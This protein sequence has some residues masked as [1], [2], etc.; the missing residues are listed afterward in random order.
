MRVRDQYGAVHDI[1]ESQLA[2]EPWRSCEVVAEVDQPEPVDA[3]KPQQAPSQPDIKPIK[4]AAPRPA[5]ED[6]E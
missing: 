4:K 5:S 1:N 6:K 2:Y 3:P